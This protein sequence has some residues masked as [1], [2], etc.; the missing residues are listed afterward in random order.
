MNKKGFTII[1]LLIAVS[2]MVLLSVATIFLIN[3]STVLNKAKDARMKK[4]LLR[5]RVA[6]EEYYSDEGCFPNQAIV[7]A[8]MLE[9]NCDKAVFAPWLPIW[10][11]DQT[12]KPYKIAVETT[13]CP[14]WYKVMT[15]LGNKNDID[16][17]TDWYSGIKTITGGYTNSQ[18]NYGVS[19]QNILW[20]D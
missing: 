20:S 1:E 14:K 9:S 5:I 3:P 12:K 4:D 19:S 11:C 13:T 18:V 16:I 10:T 7:D 8:L 6:F 2:L 15:N 17:P